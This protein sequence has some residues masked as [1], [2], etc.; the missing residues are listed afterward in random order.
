MSWVDGWITVHD[1]QSG[2]VLRTLSDPAL[3]WYFHPVALSP[4]GTQLA[5]S[6]PDHT[7][8][9]HRI[10]STAEPVL[11]GRHTD[12]VRALAYSPDG[13]TLASASMDNS[14]KLWDVEKGE[15]RLALRGHSARLNAVAF[16]PDG[17]LLASAGDDETVRLWDART[18]LVLMVLRPGIES[19]LS[20]GFSPDGLYLACG[21]D[22]VC[23]YEIA[24]LHER[25]ELK[26]HTYTVYDAAFH[27]D[28]SV[29]V[30]ASANHEVFVWDSRTG[31]S[32]RRWRCDPISQQPLESL[33]LSPSDRIV[34]IGTGEYPG[35]LLN[36]DFSVHLWDIDSGPPGRLLAGP[37]APVAALAFDPKGERLAAGAWDG[38]LF[39]WDRLSGRELLADH[40]GGGRVNS[41][42]FLDL[43]RRV[44]AAASDGRVVVYDL[45]GKAPPRATTIPGGIA[46][47]AV[48]A[49]EAR[50]VVGGVEGDLTLVNLADLATAL[51][52]KSVHQG[53]IRG[54]AITPDGKHLI[55]GGDDHRVLMHDPDTLQTRF[56]FPPHDGPVH[57]LAVSPDGCRLAIAGVEQ[58]VIVW[59]LNSLEQQFATIG[60]SWNSFSEKPSE[61]PLETLSVKVP[62]PKSAIDRAWD[63]MGLGETLRAAN[64]PA[65]AIWP[66]R[67]AELAWREILIGQ[68][69]H[70]FLQ[71]EMAV[72]LA[73]IADI[74]RATGQPDQAARSIDKALVLVE[75]LRHEDPRVAFNHCR[76]LALAS[77]PQGPR[78]GPLADR[79][80]TFLRRAIAA[81]YKDRRQINENPDL[82]PIRDRADFQVLVADRSI[83]LGWPFLLQRG[84]SRLR[85]GRIKEAIADGSQCQSILSMLLATDPAEPA[86]LSPWAASAVDLAAARRLADEPRDDD[87]ELSRAIDVLKALKEPAAADWLTLARAY[88]L[89]TEHDGQAAKHALRALR[90]AVARG[91]R[92]REFLTSDPALKSLRGRAD[93]RDLNDDLAFPSSPAE[94]FQR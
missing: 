1:A 34:A 46:R 16:H 28:D 14:V 29:L 47:C 64:K 27:P 60:L 57:K 62:A 2:A 63:F 51:T 74:Q 84:R 66:Y 90:E 32:R 87:R 24:G 52:R 6:G 15:E 42:A 58:Q 25:R 20:V 55:T 67:Q 48:T 53:P 13:M 56:A 38:S 26:G 93:F 73:A 82:D 35:V 70:P 36:P 45:A 83:R 17:N 92:D 4:D 22:T 69:D 71:S 43:G 76:V 59:D 33:A 8:R 91:F 94:I 3:G 41:V 50:L 7:V 68:P 30:S 85:Q 79:A 21:H 78:G 12:F 65:D 5:A 61:V 9:L 18:G 10:D 89:R 88:A 19:V 40:V 49:D 86:L 31:R 72:T 11:L 54:V 75:P 37:K 81:G 80:I 39:V 44:V 77:L 23:L